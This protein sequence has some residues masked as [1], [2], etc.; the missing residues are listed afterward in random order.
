MQVQILP[1]FGP[2]VR[3]VS[4]PNPLSHPRRR[5][6][7]DPAQR[8]NAGLL[9]GSSGPS[10]ATPRWSSTNARWRTASRSSCIAT[11][12]RRRWRSTRLPMPPLERRKVSMTNHRAREREHPYPIVA[13]PCYPATSR[14]GGSHGRLVPVVL[15][16]TRLYA[17]VAGGGVLSFCRGR[18][19]LG[20]RSGHETG[21]GLAGVLAPR[22]PY[23][24]TDHGAADDAGM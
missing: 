3:L 24:S 11:T 23:D 20:D 5:P 6:H 12:A 22:L 1:G 8:R 16:Q 7:A 2:C 21:P 19:W 18:A 10:H 17:Y 13:P 4:T 15:L 9:P 14:K